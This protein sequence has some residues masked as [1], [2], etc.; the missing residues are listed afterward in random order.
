[1]DKVNDKGQENNAGTSVSIKQAAEMLNVSPATIRR[2]I[3]NGEIKAKKAEGKNGLQWV[4]NPADLAESQEVKEVIPVTYNL[5]QEDL[6]AIVREAV[7]EEL[8][9]LKQKID[10]LEEQLEEQTKLLPEGKE[11]RKWYEFWK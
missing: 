2:R 1:M 7:K 10:K 5:T 4:I 3:K 8:E 11:Q 6:K 9:P